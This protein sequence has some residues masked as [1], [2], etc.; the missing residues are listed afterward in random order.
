MNIS[1]MSLEDLCEFRGHL[2]TEGLDIDLVTSF[3]LEKEE[4]Y[5][6]SILE[7]GPGGAAAAASIG[8]G[9]GGVGY[10]NATIGGM[11]N[12]SPAQPSIYAGSTSGS[13][14]SD[15]GGTVGSGDISIPYNPGGRKKTFQKIAAPLSDRKGTNKRRKNKI[16]M[17]L[18]NVFA[19]KQDFTSNQGGVKKKNVMNFS[20]FDKE[21]LS[22]VT[23][24]KQ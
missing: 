6:N 4:K 11:G 9:G 7:D 17:G 5:T 23:K 12:V 8:I 15:G 18:K 13:A 10:A 22:K 20:Q 14:F 21:N 19:N 16:L 24:V 2:I 3:I 1:E